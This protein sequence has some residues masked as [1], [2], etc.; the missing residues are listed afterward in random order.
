[1]STIN[2][3]PAY[4]AVMFRNSAV[5]AN[6]LAGLRVLSEVEPMIHCSPDFVKAKYT[7]MKKDN[8]FLFESFFAEGLPAEG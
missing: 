6:A 4:F 3:N 8:D 2:Q 1:M 5:M 7:M